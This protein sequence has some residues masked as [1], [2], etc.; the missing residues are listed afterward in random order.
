MKKKKILYLS[1]SRLP[2]EKANGLQTVKMCEYFARHYDIELMYPKR[3]NKINS[4]ILYY[5]NCINKFQIT[6]VK[7]YDFKYRNFILFRDLINN[8]NYK[9]H[10]VIYFFNTL[11]QIRKKNFDYIFI[12]DYY[13]LYLFY[14]LNINLDKIIF[15]VHSIPKNRLFTKII[16]KILCTIFISKKNFDK[17]KSNI[18]LK[19][20]LLPDASEIREI[21]YS[22]I[23]ENKFKF[24]NYIN[25]AYIGKVQ[26]KGY[27]K[28]SFFIESLYFY[29]NSN[30]SKIRLLI[31]GD[32]LTNLD[33]KSQT[34]CKKMLIDN[35]LKF[36]D[37]IKYRNLNKIYSI[38]DI[39]CI[40]YQ[41]NNHTEYASP[42]KIFE[43]IMFNKPILTSNVG[44]TLDI[45]NKNE[46]YIYEENNHQSL[47]DN[48]KNIEINFPNNLKKYSSDLAFK[49]S[50]KKR[51]KLLYS[52]LENEC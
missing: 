34:Y 23:I 47:V 3:F 30:N 36:I 26:A 18:K 42:L 40:P 16:E 14:K 1:I 52:Y 4:N 15:E 37:H 6:E 19:S 35:K 43:Y 41:K 31:I 49:Y 22:S 17:Y 38:I 21:T 11:L 46:A 10:I 2:T 24:K 50:W 33:Y 12:R 32:S 13:L 27:K 29:L 28:I 44:D 39:A 48:L 45:F 51:C 9:F 20:I 5:Y 25:L 7:T 8:Y